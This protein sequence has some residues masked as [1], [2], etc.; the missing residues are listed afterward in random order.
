MACEHMHV[1]SGNDEYFMDPWTLESQKYPERYEVVSRGSTKTNMRVQ[2]VEITLPGN[3]ATHNILRSSVRL[4]GSTVC[5]RFHGVGAIVMPRD[6]PHYRNAITVLEPCDV[7]EVGN[8]FV[9][10]R[11][12]EFYLLDFT[13]KSLK[14]Y[15]TACLSV[16][17]AASYNGLIWLQFQSK[18]CLVPTFID[19]ESGEKPYHRGDRTITGTSFMESKC[20]QGS[21]LRDSCQFVVGL[22]SAATG[23]D[24][25]DLVEGTVTHVKPYLGQP[26]EALTFVGFNK[27]KFQARCMHNEAC[28]LTRERI[29]RDNG[30]QEGFRD[31]EEGRRGE[32]DEGRGPDDRR[33]PN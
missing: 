3:L 23:M 21:K 31:E 14:K 22:A 10:K 4:Y 28:F 32:E 11:S 24:V 15:D 8:Q 9:L 20:F 1:F 6:K 16:F 26:D 17:P 19:L 30:V 33:Q 2:G 25:V 7:F 12:D 27:G 5:F 18:R 29:L 13:D